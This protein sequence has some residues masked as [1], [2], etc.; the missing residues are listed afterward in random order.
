MSFN[1]LFE[2]RNAIMDN[3]RLYTRI[4]N[5][6]QLHKKKKIIQLLEIFTLQLRR[7]IYG[8]ISCRHFPILYNFESLCLNRATRS[9]FTKSK[10][11]ENQSYA[12]KI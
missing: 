8:A 5:A 10:S 6:C 9:A 2:K 7:Y 12:K 4:K 1:Y 11:F 3:F